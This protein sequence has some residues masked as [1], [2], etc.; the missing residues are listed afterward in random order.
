MARFD[1]YRISQ[2]DQD[3]FV[4]DVQS[5]FVS[6]IGTRVVVPLV[7]A[8]WFTPPVR[9]LN[10]FVEIAGQRLMVL[11][12][13]LV[14]VPVRYLRNPVASLTNRHDDITRALDILLSGY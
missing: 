13:E 6:A 2:A 1:V 12:Q 14:S 7:P 8:P 10:P 3:Q 5:D 9:D 4:V 11:T